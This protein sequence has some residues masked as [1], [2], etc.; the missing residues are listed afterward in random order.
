MIPFKLQKWYLDLIAN[1]GHVLYLYFVVT[2]VAGISQGY[3]SAHLTLPDASEFKPAVHAKAAVSA[4]RDRITIGNSILQFKDN[5]AH[6][7]LDLPKLTIAL[8]YVPL[9]DVWKPGGDGLLLKG[10][11][12]LS[13]HVPQIEAAI[14]GTITYNS[15]ETQVRGTG[16]HDYVETT[17]PP[18]RF[19]VSELLWGRAHC[20]SYS[21]VYDQIKTHDG[22]L[23]QHLVLDEKNEVHD[24]IP[25]LTLNRIEGREF[26]VQADEK[27][28]QTIL[29]HNSFT[30]ELN[31]R[32][33]LESGTL[34]TD[35][36]VKPRLLKHFLARTACNGRE[37]KMFSEAVLRVNGAP[38]YGSAIHERVS[39]GSIGE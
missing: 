14:E 34:V 19:A 30:L 12:Y 1:D 22:S 27:D 3:V 5:Q 8:T 15:R 10:K 33:V 25:Q 4:N 28:Q 32:H 16:Y 20:G 13:W 7:K 26:K 18:W 24:G 17:M 39:F 37:L 11:D 23:L 36:R 29:T 35:D 6:V 2:K 9:T 21:V 38:V 31:R